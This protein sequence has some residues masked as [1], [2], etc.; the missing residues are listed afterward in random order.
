MLAE[1]VLVKAKQGL[2]SLNGLYYSCKYDDSVMLVLLCSCK[3]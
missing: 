3:D 2:S 1:G